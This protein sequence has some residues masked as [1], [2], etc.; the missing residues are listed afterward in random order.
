MGDTQ[1]F[2]SDRVPQADEVLKVGKVAEAVAAGGTTFQ[3][4]AEAIE[5]V[6]RQGRYYRLAAEQLG[7]IEKADVNT[8]RLTPRGRRYVAARSTAERRRLLIGGM[9]ENNFIRAVLDYIGEA[10]PRG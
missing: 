7:F 1:M 3:D 4:I 2:D 8:S 5:M 10:G 9:M 6:E